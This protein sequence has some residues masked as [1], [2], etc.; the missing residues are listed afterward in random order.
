MKTDHVSLEVKLE[1]GRA[2]SGGSRL[3]NRLCKRWIQLPCFLGLAILIATAVCPTRAVAQNLEVNGGYVHVTGDFGMDGF[4]LGAAW[5]FNPRVAMA[6]DFDSAW[7][8]SNI[9]TFELTSTGGIAVKNH[10]QNYLVGPRVFFSTKKIMKYRVDPFAEFQIGGSHLSSKLDSV[11]SGSQSASD[12]AFT[13]LLGGGADYRLSPNWT[14]RMK[15]DL[16]RTHFVNQGQSRLRL[17]L[18]VAYTFGG[19]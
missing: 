16:L 8:T 6:F 19:K 4:N 13:W 10:I 5:W 7:D 2:I 1:G 3:C 15:L 12:N 17:G 18:G 14:A 9:G 11:T